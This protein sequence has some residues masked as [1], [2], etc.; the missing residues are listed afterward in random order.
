MRTHTFI[1][2]RGVTTASPDL[3]LSTAWCVGLRFNVLGD[4]DCWVN[5]C[6]SGVMHFVIYVL[7]HYIVTCTM[8]F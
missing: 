7:L 6:M 3:C 5:Y 8:L 2:K 1:G 4:L